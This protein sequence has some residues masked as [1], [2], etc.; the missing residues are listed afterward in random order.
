VTPAPVPDDTT[1]TLAPGLTAGSVDPAALL[2]AH[3]STLANRSETTRYER[4]VRLSNGTVLARTERTTAQSA[5]RRLAR[6]RRLVESPDRP[7]R[8]GWWRNAT[9]Q[10]LQRESDDRGT[11]YNYVSMDGTPTPETLPGEAL[12]AEGVRRLADEPVTVRVLDDGRF[13][14][15][16]VDLTAEGFLQSNRT[17]SL[18]VDEHGRISTYRFAY[19]DYYEGRDVRVV[20]TVRVG[21]V[22]ETT[23]ERPDWLPTAVEETRPART[24]RTAT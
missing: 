12:L 2:A 13:R 21:R 19:D 16:A 8:S 3:G 7:W 10:Y 17:L 6:G 24:N 15:R 1:G 11:Y 20:E 14:V 4:T 22:G 9:A 5:D 18:V 23:V